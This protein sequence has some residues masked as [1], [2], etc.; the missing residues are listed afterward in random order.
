LVATPNQLGCTF[1]ICPPVRL[2]IE[3]FL[4]VGFARWKK[5]VKQDYRRRS[6]TFDK[7]LTIAEGII[8]TA[9][10]GATFRREL[11]ELGSKATIIADLCC[12]EGRKQG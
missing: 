12:S 10:R 7:P 4:H 9:L 3:H 1:E 11:V 8:S 6:K 2:P 5:D